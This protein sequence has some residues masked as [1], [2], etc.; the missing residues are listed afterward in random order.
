MWTEKFQMSNLSLEKAEQAEIKLPKSV[1]S[2]KKQESSRKN[3]YFI[4]YSRAFD[5][6]SQQAVE[7]S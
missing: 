2:K 5:C 4:D 1:G 3:I 6:G 7:N